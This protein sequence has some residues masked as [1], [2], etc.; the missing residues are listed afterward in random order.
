VRRSDSDGRQMTSVEAV[1]D[2]IDAR[3]LDLLERRR[4]VQGL[5][6]RGW[7]I[8]RALLAA[9]ILGLTVAFLVAAA[10]FGAGDAPSNR[11]GEAGE[12]GLFLVALPI[13]VVAAKLNGLYDK[14]EER[15]DHSTVDDF[16]GV[17]S[18]VTITSWSIFATADLTGFA[19]PEFAK[20]MVFWLVATTAVPLA[21]ATGRAYCRRQ[22]QY[23]QNTVIVGAGEVGQS[24]AQKLLKHPEYGLNLVGFVDAMPR[25]PIDGIEHVALL[26]E[27]SEL[28][29]LVALLDIERVIVAFSSD[30]H[31]ELLDAIR[32]LSELDVQVDIVPR[33]FEVVGPGVGIHA[34]EGVTVV[35]LAPFRLSRSSQLLKRT[36]DVVVATVALIVLLPVLAIVAGLIA[37]D[38]R[39]PVF[40]RQVRRGSR[41]EMFR[42]W[43]FRT[44]SIDAEMR[45]DEIRHLNLHLLPG[46]DARMFKVADDPRTTRVGRVLRK[47]S[48]DEL[49]QLLNVL[50]GDMS[51]VGPRPLILD[52][53]RYV[54]NWGRR[55]LEQK[56]G[57]TGL[58]QVLGRSDIPF[59]EMVRLDYLYVTGWS[60][61]GD[62]RLILR[63]VPQLLRTSRGA[64]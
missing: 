27:L 35:G 1:Y 39:G 8:R 7:M 51:L 33:L 42:I 6:R 15:T 43:K 63:T 48:I 45:K 9:D 49:P 47:Y 26:G 41:D 29:R 4:R 22:V 38:S 13:W 11:L 20:V 54:E 44:M 23:L 64:I 52:E 5:K 62:V 2:L 56:P 18:L 14:D 59:S 50:R 58:W 12:Y 17:F 3:T 37:A 34:I 32:L 25:E 28:P 19:K 57:M 61:M 46:G 31:D 40:F 53:D 30:G 10:I 21:R 55:R 24:L 60:L 36:M 16:S